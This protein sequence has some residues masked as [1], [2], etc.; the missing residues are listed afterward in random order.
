MNSNLLGFWYEK[1]ITHFSDV[2]WKTTFRNRRTSQTRPVFI[3]RLEISWIVENRTEITGNLLFGLLRILRLITYSGHYCRDCRFSRVYKEFLSAKLREMRNST[4]IFK[5]RFKAF[6]VIFPIIFHRSELHILYYKN[7]QIAYN[8]LFLVKLL[9]SVIEKNKSILWVQD[10]S[11]C[12]VNLQNWVISSH[13]WMIFWKIYKQKLVFFFFC[14]L[15]SNFFDICT[16]ILMVGSS[17]TNSLPYYLP[18]SLPYYLRF[19][20][21]CLKKRATCNYAINNY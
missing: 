20:P 9:L 10:L 19:S 2:A 1:G 7:L 18:P 6:S 14:F 8:Q 16:C 17:N 4:K 13:F 21:W 12:V 5:T 15:H 11:R 3:E